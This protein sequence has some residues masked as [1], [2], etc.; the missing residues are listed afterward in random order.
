LPNVETQE[1]ALQT[2]LLVADNPTIGKIVREELS[3]AGYQ[4]RWAKNQDE[5]VSLW[6]PDQYDVVFVDIRREKDRGQALVR[7]IKAVAPSQK[8]IFLKNGHRQVA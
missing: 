7:Q 5:A 8:V 2:V 3:G 1:L 6:A 4:V